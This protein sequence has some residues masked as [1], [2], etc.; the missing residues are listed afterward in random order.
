MATCKVVVNGDPGLLSPQC[1][2]SHYFVASEEV[3]GLSVTICVL[4]G[5]VQRACLIHIPTVCVCSE[6]DRQFIQQSTE[7][8]LIQ[9]FRAYDE[10]CDQRQ[11]LE[12]KL[13]EGED[14][15]KKLP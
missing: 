11:E 4:R 13:E 12:N 5:I 3:E 15:V 9:L 14:M 1:K 10:V 7:T 2:N 6:E 8:E